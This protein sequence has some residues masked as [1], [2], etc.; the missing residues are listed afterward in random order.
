MAENEAILLER[1]STRADAEAFAELVR[2]HV[3]LVYSTSWRVLKNQSD[4]ADV[5]QETFFELTRCAGRISG[6]LGVWLHHVATRKSIDLIRRNVHRRRRERACARNRPEEVRTWH[7]L[8]GYVDEALDKLDDSTKS[9][10]LE[11][12]LAGKT[13]VQIAR[14]RGV[15]QAT[16]SR[17]INDS[18]EQ[19]RGILRR[20]GLLVAAASLGALLTANASQAAPAAILAELSK[21]AMVG[22]T[23]AALGGKAAVGAGAGAMKAAFATTTI[24][25]AAS[26]VGYVYHSRR[27]E[28]LAQPSIV[29][30]VVRRPAPENEGNRSYAADHS[31]TTSQLQTESDP[32]PVVAAPEIEQIHMAGS[33][34][35]PL[36]SPVE[37]EITFVSVGDPFSGVAAVD[38][39]TPEAVVYSFLTLI[40]QG[41]LDQVDKCFADA[42][43]V[44][45]DGLYPRYLGQPIRLVEVTRD[46][47]TAQVRWEAT[48]HT[49]FSHQGE[50]RLPG[51]FVP[52]S[53]RLIRVGDLWKLV[54]LDE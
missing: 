14:E 45:A 31:A 43:E 26:V 9:L 23:G 25:V 39:R 29:S 24:L 41:D 5:T 27:P 49:P 48:V 47:D 32:S 28:P 11:H 21:M 34:L 46:D 19:L 42:N 16:V 44:V 2:R 13:T 33:I 40:D 6:S 3:R 10:L 30:Q 35:E 52:L 1:F 15:S 12:F 38:L 50:D 17:R 36:A 18:L 20:Q 22:T 8:S 37:P 4:A 51:E 53:S 54:T 7:E